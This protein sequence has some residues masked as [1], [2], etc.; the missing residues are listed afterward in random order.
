VYSHAWT[1][2]DTVI[3][4]N[5]GM[6]HSVEPYEEGSKREHIRTTLVGTEPT[7]PAPTDPA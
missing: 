5:A 6:L 1:V 3:W 2:G 4:D 7:D